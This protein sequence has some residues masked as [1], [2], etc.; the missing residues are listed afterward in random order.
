MHRVVQH[1]TARIMTQAQCDDRIMTHK[2]I[3]Q[4]SE[5]SSKDRFVTNGETWRVLYDPQNKIQSSM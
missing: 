4:R 3:K 1:I 5:L 2:H